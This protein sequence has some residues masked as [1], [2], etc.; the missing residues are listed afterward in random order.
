MS[1]AT[2]GL[3]SNDDIVIYA[4]PIIIF[5]VPCR[6]AS[7]TIL[8][9]DSS[10][11]T[12]FASMDLGHEAASHG[13]RVKRMSCAFSRQLPWD[14]WKMV[15]RKDLTCLIMMGMTCKSFRA[16]IENDHD[17]WNQ[18]FITWEWRNVKGEL[19]QARAMPR[20]GWLDHAKINRE[21]FLSLIAVTAH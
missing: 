13:L 6:S 7:E 21:I 12:A 4:V 1:N 14:A 20:M 18:M 16:N 11:T 10:L 8:A 15:I 17:I 2:F 19:V 3:T 5:T 9:P